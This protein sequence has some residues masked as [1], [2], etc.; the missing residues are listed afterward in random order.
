VVEAAVVAGAAVVVA[1]ADSVVAAGALLV[2][3]ATVVANDDFDELQLVATIAA[4]T[5]TARK[6]DRDIVAPTPGRWVRG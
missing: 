5:A 4:T 3:G 6:P 2:D 1:G